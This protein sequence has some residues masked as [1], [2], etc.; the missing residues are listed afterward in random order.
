MVRRGVVVLLPLALVAVALACNNGT[1]IDHPCSNIP[2]GGCP[3]ADG[4]SCDDPICEAVYLCRQNNVWELQKQC[5]ARAPSDAA[6]V[7]DA[8]AGDADASDAEGIRDASIDAPPG[9]FGGPGCQDLQLGDCA[10]GVALSC[11]SSCCGCEDLF[12]CTSGA[13]SYWGYCGANG[14]VYA[15]GQH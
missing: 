7:T 15:P 6:T 11:A 9:A 2:E 8:A 3:L 4:L 1:Q 10:L 13:W 14:P 12:V 5:P